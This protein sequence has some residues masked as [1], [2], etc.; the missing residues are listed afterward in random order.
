MVWPPTAAEASYSTLC[1]RFMGPRGFFL[2]HKAPHPH[3]LPRERELEGPVPQAVI[4]I[5]ALMGSTLPYPVARVQA[6]RRQRPF[7]YPVAGHITVP[8]SR[9][10]DAKANRYMSNKD[11]FLLATQCL[12][13]LLL[14]H[15]DDL[16]KPIDRQGNIFFGV[17]DSQYKLLWRGYFYP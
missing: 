9:D 17:V 8:A 7:R 4:L 1:S 15:R 14:G 6:A 13:H 10:A 5:L 16:H 3:P 11:V 12:T 2:G